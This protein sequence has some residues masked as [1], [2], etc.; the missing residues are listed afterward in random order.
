[1]AKREILV[2]VGSPRPQGA[3]ATLADEVRK[4]AEEAGAIVHRYDLHEMDIRPCSACDACLE[5]MDADC[6]IEDDMRTLYP[7]L[8][9]ADALVIASPVYWFDVSAQTKLFID[10]GF[11]AMQGPKGSALKGKEIGL[12]LAYGAE[13]L[14]SSG[15][16]NAI[17]SFTDIFDFLGADIV[18]TVHGS[19]AGGDISR[20]K[21]VMEQAYQLGQRLGCGRM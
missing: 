5:S 17:A 16:E 9:R 1:M 11:Y 15:G 21:A 19:A 2:V 8:R 14:E 3:C 20:E 18:G 6:V 10:R 12:L 7:L 13:D 4:G